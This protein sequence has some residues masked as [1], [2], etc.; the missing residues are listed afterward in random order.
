MKPTFYFLIS[1][2]AVG[3]L[4]AASCEKSDQGV[5]TGEL[6]DPI[7]IELRSSEKEMVGADQ[8][9][10][11]EFFERVFLE[12]AKEDDENFMVSPL[13]LSMALAMTNNGAAGATKTAMLSAL[14]LDEYSDEE[15]NEYYKK[16][17]GALLKT[18]PSTKL[19][20]ANAI[21]ANQLL[22]SKRSLSTRISP[23]SATVQR[24]DFSNL[25]R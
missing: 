9:F 22:I 16:L 10:A 8:T 23:I 18:D 21:F 1:I 5:P 2:V 13:S 14:K 25:I 3:T 4:L 19:S 7:K 24:V 17:K 11:F 12:E 15:V 20:I 6:P